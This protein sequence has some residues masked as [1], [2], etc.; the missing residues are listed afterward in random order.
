[1]ASPTLYLTFPGN[2][3]QALE[4]YA[5]VFGG[6]IELN[7][8]SDFSR[9]D[10][11]A[12][13]IA[14]GILSGGPVPLFAADAGPEETTV[15]MEGVMVTLLGTA[16]PETLHAWFDKLAEGGTVLDPLA[17]KPWGASDGQV[18]DRYGLT[19]LI[20]YEP[21]RTLGRS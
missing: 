15:R 6:D 21:A 19:W 3:R 10:G 12:D 14:H 18:A 4:F 16:D 8:Y 20:G 1:M 2:A 13:A 17:P 11:P 9:A 5:G 7:T